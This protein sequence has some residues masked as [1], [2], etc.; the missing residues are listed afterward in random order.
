MAVAINRV[1]FIRCRALILL[2][3]FALVFIV[4]VANTA[5]AAKTQTSQGFK[6]R[7]AIEDGLIVSVDQNDSQ[8]V[9][10]S[11]AANRER[12]IGVT[13]DSGQSV[14]TF[15][16]GDNKVQVASSGITKVFVSN[17]NGDIKSGDALT[18]SPIAGFAMRATSAG[19]VVGVASQDF[20]ANQT[21]STK[22]LNVTST[23]GQNKTVKFGQID[24]QISV[25][26]WLPTGSQ[27]SPLL[28]SLRGVIGGVV[29]KPVSNIQAVTS[30]GVIFLAI[31][32]SATILYSSVSSSIRSIG[33]NPLSKGII[34]RSLMVMTVM[35]I[36]VILGAG[37]AVYL[38]LGG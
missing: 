15:A 21:A 38:I 14:V 22:T 26:N 17:L 36:L 10:K 1:L 6:V 25:Q 29:G 16:D 18:V 12:L 27:N 20:I 33:R 3:G 11:N 23:D 30:I 35:A 24:A 37:S 28:N 4:L 9:E 13:V 5:F 7:G 2:I 19:K 34:R 31:I 8:F 32:A